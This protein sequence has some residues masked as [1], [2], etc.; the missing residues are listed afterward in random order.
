MNYCFW[1]SLV[2]LLV[3]STGCA[4]KRAP[5]Q[6]DSDGTN[7]QHG[8]NTDTGVGINDPSSDSDTMMEDTDIGDDFDSNHNTD[9]GTDTSTDT[10]ADANTDADTDTDIDSNF[11]TD[12]NISSDTDDTETAPDAS[13]IPEIDTAPETGGDGGDTD[14]TVPSYDTEQP[15][16]AGLDCDIDTGTG[17]DTDS[18]TFSDTGSDIEPGCGNGV[19]EP[20]EACDDGNADYADG[21][22]PQCHI[23]PDCT[24]GTC[25]TTCGD[26]LLLASNGEACDDGN[27]EDGDGC[28]ATCEI[29]PGYSCEQEETVY[30]V[31]YPVIY[32]DFLS[33]HPDFQPDVSS[34]SPQKGLL[35]NRLDE[36]GKPQF[37]GADGDGAISS[38]DSF[39]DWYHDVSGINSAIKSEMTLFL[40]DDGTLVNRFGE[41]GEQWEQIVEEWCGT[42]AE[43]DGPCRSWWEPNPCEEQAD[44]MTQCIERENIY[45]GIFNYGAYD[46]NPLFFPIDNHPDAITPLAKYQTATIPTEFLR[47]DKGTVASDTAHNFHFTSEFRFWFYFNGVDTHHIDISGDDDMWVF[48]NGHLAIDLGG[49]HTHVQGN[50][51]L[52][53]V[54]QAKFDITEAGLYEVTVFHA[55]RKTSSSTFTL[56]LKGFDFSKSICSKTG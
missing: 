38:K 31:T 15:P 25:L 10:S 20:G 27:L 43:S 41:R 46:G 9:I 33:D 17:P 54:N 16:D 35:S 50:V 49:L 1:W 7:T 51:T 24:S 23:T 56:R 55:E 47:N 28:S 37:V 30:D 5:F 42:V 52:G 53:S 34:D 2:P 14:T 32:R 45:Y 6:V 4:K 26:G 13:T 22:T 44:E 48:I 8:T 21:C 29:E 39:Y 3:L 19:T 36:F 11:D 12:I 18:D 40:A